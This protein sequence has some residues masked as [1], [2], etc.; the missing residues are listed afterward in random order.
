MRFLGFLFGV[1]L[2]GILGNNYALTKCPGAYVG[3]ATDTSQ[4]SVSC[5]LCTL[6]NLTIVQG[7]SVKIYRII[8]VHCQ[9]FRQLTKLQIVTSIELQDAS[10]PTVNSCYKMAAI[11]DS[12]MRNL[13]MCC[14]NVPV[15]IKKKRCYMDNLALLCL[16][17]Y[18]SNPCKGS[19][20]P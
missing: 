2:N 4:M 9:A 6:V 20:R 18:R 5:T 1:P 8:T 16:P 7:S 10:T 14:R 15:C 17:T 19:I 11:S 3:F 12:T 13:G